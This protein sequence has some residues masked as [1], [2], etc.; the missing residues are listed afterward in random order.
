MEAPL[1]RWLKPG[2][3]ILTTSDPNLRGGQDTQTL[4][5]ALDEMGK[6][7]ARAQGLKKAITTWIGYR[8]SDNRLI[9]SIGAPTVPHGPPTFRGILRVGERQL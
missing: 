3:H 6:R 4:A 9:V 2:V 1:P 8:G 7:S 5:A